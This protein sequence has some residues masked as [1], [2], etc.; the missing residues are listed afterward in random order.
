MFYATR[1]ELADIVLSEHEA[2]IEGLARH[3]LSKPKKDRREFLDLF[4][5]KHGSRMREDLENRIWELHKAGFG[6]PPSDQS[7]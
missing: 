2:K 6:K 4:E 3:V 7:R 1:E 5:S